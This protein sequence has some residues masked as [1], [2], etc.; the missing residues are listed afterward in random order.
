MLSDVTWQLLKL[1]EHPIHL[2]LG[3]KLLL[4]LYQ[5]LKE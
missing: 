3:K 5:V 1:R 2:S 4:F